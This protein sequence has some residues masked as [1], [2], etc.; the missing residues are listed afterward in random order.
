MSHCRLEKGD[1]ARVSFVLH[2]LAEGDAGRIVYTDVHE[3]PA[4][5]EMTVDCAGF[6]SGHP[7]ADRADPAKLLD[8]DVDELARVCPLIAADRLRRF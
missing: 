7:M 8:V 6:P 2:D 4:D 1:G 3:L 5:A